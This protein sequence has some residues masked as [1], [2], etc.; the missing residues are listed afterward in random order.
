M[1]DTRLADKT[2]LVTGSGQG[3]GRGIA[4]VFARAGARVVVA[5]RTASSGQA[6]VDSITATGGRAVLVQTDVQDPDQI[7]AAVDA[8]ISTFG[9]L[10][11]MVHNAA[12]FAGG[13]VEDFDPADLND[14]LSTNLVAAFH[15][16]KMCV[17]HM[18]AAGGGR[19][20]Y[21]SSVTG[22]RVA[23]PG[24]S[25]YAASKSGLNGFIRTAALELAPFGITVNGIEPGFIKTPA[26]DLIA[27]AAGQAEMAKYIPAGEMGE[28]EDIAYAM[29]YLASAEARY[30]T[31]QTICVDGGS[32]LPESPLF[33][34]DDAEG[35][36]A[37]S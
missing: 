25:Y 27:D 21:T 30:V 11:V 15:L 26:I 18:K 20:L 14:A 31:G 4:Q 34:D 28:P 13:M 1:T 8:T 24:A 12:S 7:Q 10:D 16:A 22:P 19:L 6:T 37:L 2:A 29:L 3:I 9:T 32:T 23:M 5:T 36:T 17:P 35:V 33:A